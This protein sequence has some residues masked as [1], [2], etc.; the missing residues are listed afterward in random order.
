MLKISCACY[1][2]LSSAI[3]SQFTPKV[4]DAVKK[5]AKKSLKTPLLGVQVVY[6]H[7]CW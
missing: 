3:S 6:S 7:W 4:C 1:F 2:G 5:I